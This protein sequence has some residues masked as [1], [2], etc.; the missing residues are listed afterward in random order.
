MEGMKFWLEVP[1][2]CRVDEAGYYIVQRLLSA[3]AGI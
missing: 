1:K 3:N 2:K